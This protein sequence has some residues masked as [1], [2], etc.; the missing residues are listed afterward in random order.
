M[1]IALRTASDPLGQAAAVRRAVWSIDREL[2]VEKVRTMEEI[3]ERSLAGRR[4]Y[5]VLLALFAG[6]ALL[7]A[8]VGVYGVMAY[9][10]NRRVQE[11]GVRL[12]LGAQRAAVL[13]MVAGE[14]LRLA[15]LGIA[16]GLLLAFGA[17]RFLRSLLFGMS[18]TDALTY[19]AVAL[20]L[21]AL[22]LLSAYLPAR[23]ATRID[24]LVALRWD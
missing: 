9:S 4:S 5:S 23:R 20:L 12:A 15:G 17:S 1:S 8:V 18:S 14:G 2:P 10:V 6:V 13:R 7:L 11:I 19:V 3:V 24:P 21:L 22:A 16:L